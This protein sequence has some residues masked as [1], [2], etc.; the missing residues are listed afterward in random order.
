VVSIIIH[1][2]PQEIDQLEQT[3]I[4]LKKCSVYTNKEYLVEV[5]L[6]NNLTRWEKSTFPQHFFINKL[7]KLEK[8]TKSWAKTNFWVS[9]K[10]ESM[11]CTDPRRKCIQYDTEATIW[12]DVDIIFS[13][14]ILGHLEAAIDSIDKDYYIITPETTRLWD[15]TWDVITNKEAL[16]DEANHNNYFK[17]DP[18][19]TTGLKGDVYLKPINTFKWAG[20]W[21][22]CISSKLVKKVTIPKEMGPYYQDDTF[23]MVCYNELKKLGVLNPTQYIMVNEVIIENNL[24]RFNPYQEYL[25]T[26][27]KR[28]EF[29]KIAN[30]NFNLCVKNTIE[31]IKQ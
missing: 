8:L 9:E 14:T 6:N 18:Y 10:G 28:E 30:D 25:H 16:K 1:I 29:K 23:L 11:G 26:I 4:S 20:G 12:L 24:F 27:D 31:N 21:F 5:V 13:D 3:L 17:R 2:L 19:I 7:S 15:S 22:T